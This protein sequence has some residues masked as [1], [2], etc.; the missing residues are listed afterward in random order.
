MQAK[1]KESLDRAT[2][3]E[4]LYSIYLLFYNEVSKVA[5]R[6]AEYLKLY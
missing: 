2:A 4:V 5:A 6:F 1:D 3:R